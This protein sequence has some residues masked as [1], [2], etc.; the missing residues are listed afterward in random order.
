MH[1]DRWSFR[2]RLIPGL[3][4]LIPGL[5]L[6]AL[7]VWQ[8]GRAEQ[9]QR[10][11]ELAEARSKMPA[12]DLN[13]PLL[14]GA[15]VLAGRRAG[16]T[17]VYASLWNILL[18]NQVYRG[19]TGY[20]VFTPFRIDG[21]DDWILI[22]RG[23]V[24][25]GAYREQLPQITTPAGPVSVQGRLQE[26]P[27]SGILLN[28]NF[29]ET[30]VNGLVRTQSLQIERLG[31]ITGLK[32]RPYIVRLDAGSEAGLIRDYQAADA[33]NARHL[34]YAYQWFAMAAMVLFIYLY[35]SIN[36]TA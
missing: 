28:E 22:G 1:A 14:P 10:L 11:F 2:P 21:T 5:V 18:D 36:R 7:G 25:A 34:A 15:E 6:V 23:W 8:I 31:E 29:I 35:Y 12:L 33:G 4:A 32:L 13:G 26:P 24:P 30:P 16:G 3:L 19:Q 20:L 27:F 9:K 17:G